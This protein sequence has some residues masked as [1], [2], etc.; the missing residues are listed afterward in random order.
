MDNDERVKRG[1][2]AKALP[3][4]KREKTKEQRQGE[5][6]R[7]DEERIAEWLMPVSVFRARNRGNRKRLEVYVGD[8]PQ[9]FAID[10]CV[11]VTADSARFR[12][13]VLGGA[14]EPMMEITYRLATD[15]SIP[16]NKAL[17]QGARV[18]YPWNG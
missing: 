5:P 7:S 16:W 9:P 1:R 4:P 17:L 10:E 3:K 8:G 14:D 18:L 2:E 12:M 11:S 15:D 13:S 6:P